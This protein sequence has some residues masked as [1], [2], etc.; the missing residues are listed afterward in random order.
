M[1]QK[2]GNFNRDW[3]KIRDECKEFRRIETDTI[4]R[5]VEYAKNQGSKSAGFYYKNIC[6]NDLQSSLSC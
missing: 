4:Q 5:F 6:G 1:P 2:Q 3:K